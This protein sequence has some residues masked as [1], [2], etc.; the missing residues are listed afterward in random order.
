MNAP[1]GTT[2]SI[3][4]TSIMPNGNKFQN[5]LMFAVKGQLIP[6]SYSQSDID[7]MEKQ[8]T[9]RLWGN[10]EALTRSLDRFEQAWSK[11]NG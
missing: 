4:G 3:I 1:V 5:E 10:C 8:Y 2:G 7:H 6:D 9:K 11:A